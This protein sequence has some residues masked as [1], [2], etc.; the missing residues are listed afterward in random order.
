MPFVESSTKAVAKTVNKYR[1]KDLYSRIGEFHR[2]LKN[3]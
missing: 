1:T 3:P 2:P